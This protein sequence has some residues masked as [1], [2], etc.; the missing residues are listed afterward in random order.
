LSRASN[1]ALARSP[2]AAEFLGVDRPGRRDRPCQ[3]LAA[4]AAA[5]AHIEHLHPRPHP[6]EG[7][8]LERVA[9]RIGLP[10][11]IAAVGRCNNRGIVDRAILRGRTAR[12]DQHRERDGRACA[13]RCVME[14]LQAGS[15]GHAALLRFDLLAQCSMVAGLIW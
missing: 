6:D 11:R 4:V 14:R 10:V 2:R 15:S 7:E 13:H 1:L 3:E 5:R 8:Q 12:A 9:P